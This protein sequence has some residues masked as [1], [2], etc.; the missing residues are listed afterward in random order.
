VHAENMKQRAHKEE[1]IKAEATALAEKITAVTL[2]VGAKTSSKGKIFGS[3][4][5]IQLSEALTKEGIDVD[6]KKIL[7]KADAIKEVGEYTAV[8]KLHR[9]VT[10]E[11]KFEVV[12]E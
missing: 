10:A 7:L 9:E 1:K 8:I 3:V 2:K 4:N 11:L 5:T 6:R 12:T